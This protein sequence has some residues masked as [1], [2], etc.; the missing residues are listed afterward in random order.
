MP[1]TFL[2]FGSLQ[3]WK[4]QTDHQILP[5][6]KWLFPSNSEDYDLASS[7]SHGDFWARRSR[8]LSR[9][10]KIFFGNLHRRVRRRSSFLAQRAIAFSDQINDQSLAMQILNELMKIKNG[11]GERVRLISKTFL[12]PNDPATPR[13]LAGS[14]ISHC[15][16]GDLIVSSRQDLLGRNF[17]YPRD[18]IYPAAII[19]ERYGV[20]NG[21]HLRL[22]SS[23][24]A[25]KDSS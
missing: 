25:M 16:C 23:T 24:V 1:L 13:I 18:Q 12:P 4:F 5:S 3:L 21:S 9:Y 19:A 22:S 17:D 11:R 15:P 7:S 10:V 6:L 20:R 2:M 14:G 8:S